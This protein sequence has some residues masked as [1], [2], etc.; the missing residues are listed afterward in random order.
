MELGGV[1]EEEGDEA[2]PQDGVLVGGGMG[3][4]VEDLIMVEVVGGGV[5]MVAEEGEG[6]GVQVAVEVGD[7]EGEE[8]EI[9]GADEFISGGVYSSWKI[10]CVR[11][12][13]MKP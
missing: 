3:K 1:E 7:E 9:E 8:T 5:A 11:R 12:R 4:F 13:F 6:V 10:F 2:D